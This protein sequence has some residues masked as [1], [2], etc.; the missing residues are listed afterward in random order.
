MV[1]TLKGALLVGGQEVS[2]KTAVR[3]SQ[4]TS[5]ELETQQEACQALYIASQALHEPVAWGG[6]IVMNTRQ[7]LDTAFKELRTGTFIK[8]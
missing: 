7:E 2:E 6:P 4:G 1:F 5:L 8:R 3:L